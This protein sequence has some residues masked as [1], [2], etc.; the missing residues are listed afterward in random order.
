VEPVGFEDH[1]RSLASGR[2]ER[3]PAKAGSV[4]DALLA[5]EPGRITWPINRRRLSGAVAVTDAEALAAVGFAFRRMKLVLEPSGAAALAAALLGKLDLR[6]KTV[7]V[8][9]SGGNVDS[10]TFA[11]AIGGAH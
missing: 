5:E 1:R 8:I 9:A 10:V 7:A 2:I 3:N 4:C 6:G 11:K